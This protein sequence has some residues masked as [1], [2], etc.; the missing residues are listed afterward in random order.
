MIYDTEKTENSYA[1]LN[2][3]EYCTD[4]KRNELEVVGQEDF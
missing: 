2:Q 1:Q 4:E 3:E